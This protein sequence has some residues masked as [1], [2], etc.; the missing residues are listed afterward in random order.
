MRL[1]ALDA[2]PPPLPQLDSPWSIRLCRAE[3]PSDV[4]LVHRWMHAPHVARA[5]QQAWPRERW[6]AVLA[7]QLA[8]DHTR[9]LIASLDGRPLAY[10]EVYRVARDILGPH[11]P[12]DL[13]PHPHDLGVHIA[14]G[15][16]GQ[17]GKGLGRQLLRAVA[18]GL[19]AA[20]PA[21]IRVV[22]E[23]NVGNVASL[24][25]F[26]AAGFDRHAVI[27]LPHKQAMLMVRSR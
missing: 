1:A 25:A 24:A 3:D 21:C 11:Y 8:G 9:P 12:T 19:F 4:D 23:P 16:P 26:A 6:R 15:D 14:I 22:A 13:A 2:G 10:L 27:Q 17:T 5:W 7:E 18:C 20:D